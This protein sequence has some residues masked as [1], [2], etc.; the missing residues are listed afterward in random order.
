MAPSLLRSRRSS[1]SEFQGALG[2]GPTTCTKIYCRIGRLENKQNV[3]IR[4]RARL[5]VDTIEEVGE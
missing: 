1:E 2:C 4:I 3:I 5:W